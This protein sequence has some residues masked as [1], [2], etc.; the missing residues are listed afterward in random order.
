MAL[1]ENEHTDVRDLLVLDKADQVTGERGDADI[2]Q[3]PHRHVI[4][5]KVNPDH[6]ADLEINEQKQQILDRGAA[7]LGPWR[8]T[9]RRRPRR[10]PPRLRTAREYGSRRSAIGRSDRRTTASAGRGSWRDFSG[11][12]LRCLSVAPLKKLLSRSARAKC[13]IILCGQTALLQW[14]TQRI[15]ELRRRPAAAPPNRAPVRA[16]R[17]PRRPP[18][19]R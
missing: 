5:A 4:G 8:R 1:S 11:P 13:A 14:T 10:W 16:D 15:E 17:C 19:P 9:P 3:E 7:L 2:E 18:R 12:S 6:R